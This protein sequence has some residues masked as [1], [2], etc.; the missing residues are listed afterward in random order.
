MQSQKNP[1]KLQRQ[2]IVL[3]LT[4]YIKRSFH[5][6]HPVGGEWFKLMPTTPCSVYGNGGYGLGVSI[7]WRQDDIRLTTCDDDDKVHF[8]KRDIET[9]LLIR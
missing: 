3:F 8:R 7:V 6:R 4:S 2:T 5:V 1:P 9:I